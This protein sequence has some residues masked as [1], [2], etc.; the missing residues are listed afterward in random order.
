MMSIHTSVLVHAGFAKLFIDWEDVWAGVQ[1]FVN[2]CCQKKPKDCLPMKKRFQERLEALQVTR[3][4][5]QLMYIVDP[6]SI[7][8]DCFMPFF[9]NNNPYRLVR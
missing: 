7:P 6:T 4:E 2:G 3:Q 1:W 9:V 5:L 8:S